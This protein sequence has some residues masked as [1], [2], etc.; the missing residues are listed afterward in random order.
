MDK[1]PTTPATFW[2]QRYGESDAIWSGKVNTALADVVTERVLEPGSAL[3]LGCGE[4]ADV[5]WLAQRGWRVT[6]LD[7]SAVAIERAQ[8]AA[9]AQGL[10]TDQA[11]FETTDFTEWTEAQQFDLVTASFLQSPVAFDRQ[12][13]LGAAQDLVA[14]GGHLIVISHASFP[15]WAKDYHEDAEHQVPHEPATPESEL[16]ILQFDDYRWV[17]EVAEVRS[18]QITGP[19]GDALTLDDTVIVAR[20]TGW[21]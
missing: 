13:A 7:I 21:D 6:G 18:R 1:T 15:P 20:R 4:G 12:Y 16:E 10:S 5:I 19:D 14:P 9:T 8:A 3:D 17:V 11:Q 2:D